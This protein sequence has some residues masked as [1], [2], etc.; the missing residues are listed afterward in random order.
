LTLFA[1]ATA[2]IFSQAV[3]FARA[4]VPHSV[5]PQ[6]PGNMLTDGCLDP[7]TGLPMKLSGTLGILSIAVV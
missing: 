4:P 5:A 6:V 3:V 1:G 7:L 2:N